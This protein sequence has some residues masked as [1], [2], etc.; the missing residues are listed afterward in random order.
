M[1]G[2]VL[3]HKKTQH[4]STIPAPKSL[5]GSTSQSAQSRSLRIEQTTELLQRAQEA[6]GEER[7]AILNQAVEMN[8]PVARSIA[9]RFSNRG[10]PLDDLEQ[11]AFVGLTKAVRGFDPA[12][13]GDFLSYAVPSIVGE[14]K[15]YFRDSAW[16]VRPP[17]RIQELQGEITPAVQDLSQRLGRSPNAT[18]IA[19]L[20]GRDV[21]DVIEALGCAG[22]FNPSSLD[23]SGPGEDGFRLADQLGEEERGFAQAEALEMVARAC[24]VLSPREKRILY[25]RFIKE[26]TQQQIGA[27]LGVTQT[28]VSRLL[29]QILQRLREELDPASEAAAGFSLAS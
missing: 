11:V 25:L 17:R 8:L 18:E 7:Q 6:S 23:D 5:S 13:G 2:T 3:Q 28:Q 24:T 21:E 14:V 29:A 22:C 4:K 10:E 26:R 12:R 27:E 19:D 20:L 9:R 15:R 16:A 1:A